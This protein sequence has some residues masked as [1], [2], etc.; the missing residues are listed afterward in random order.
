MNLIENLT[1]SNLKPIQ[2]ISSDIE[3]PKENPPIIRILNQILDE[4]IEKKASD[5]HFEPYENNLRIRC[6]FDGLLTTISTISIQLA[7]MITTRIKILSNLDISE[8]RLPQDGRFSYH[9][10]STRKVD[11]RVSTC[12]TLHGEKVVLRIL[13]SQK[14]SLAL[15]ALGMSSEQIDQYR[16]ALNRSQGL[17]LVTGPT[18]SGKTMTLYSGLSYLNTD[19]KN[20]CSVEDPIEIQLAGI[21]QVPVNVKTGLTFPTALKAFLR[22]DPDV[23]MVGEIR[24]RETADIAIDASL[25]G[26][27]VLSTLHTNSAAEALVRLSNMGVPSYNIASS[28]SLIIAQRLVRCLCPHCKIPIKNLAFYETPDKNCPHCHNG[29][30]GRIGIFE[31]MPLSPHLKE[32][33]SNKQSALKINQQAQR[34]KI[35]SLRESGLNAIRSGIT[36]LAEINRVASE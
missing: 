5:I 34:E 16:S 36:C 32:L 9:F 15:D 4:A 8:R 18:G 22:Q 12:P 17:I 3:P 6:R 25:T 10:S 20:I 23:I 13:E 29:F 24:D 33:I 1:T 35:I 28:L 7:Q 2:I 31:A 26:H 11:F 21:N 27:L 19:E 30:Y 14:E